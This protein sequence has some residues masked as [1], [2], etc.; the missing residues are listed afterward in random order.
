MSLVTKELLSIVKVI[1]YILNIKQPNNYL[2]NRRVL[3][4]FVMGLVPICAI[5]F[6]A[7]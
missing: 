5:K 6:L 2:L 3:S 4:D 1:L 7:N